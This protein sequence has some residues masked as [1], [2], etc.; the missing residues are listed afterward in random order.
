MT[1]RPILPGRMGSCQ[2]A[3]LAITEGEMVAVQRIFGTQKNII[4]SKYYVEEIYASHE[5]DVIVMRSDDRGN[6]GAGEA[7]GDIVED[8]RPAFV[9]LTGTAGGYQGREEAELGDVV[10]ADF[11]SYSEFRK[12][13]DGRDRPR[14]IAYDHPSLYLRGRFADQI[15]NSGSWKR[16]VDVDRPGPGDLKAIIGNLVAGEKILGDA[17]NPYQVELL[18]EFDK[19]VAFDMESFG[20]GR[21]VFKKRNSVHY[22]P[23]YL[24]IRGISD[25]VDQAEGSEDTRNLWRGY[26]ATVAA[27][28]AKAVTVNLIEVLG[29]NKLESPEMVETHHQRRI[30]WF[31]KLI[32][33]FG[34][35]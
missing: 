35:E 22:N 1:S 21:E 8:F 9:I 4:G 5:Y 23:Q 18:E 19:A 17:T 12:W 32:R 33:L 20:V 27:A 6:T 28:F 2:T 10:I 29:S 7:V 14:Y 16:Y 30:S 24:V 26:A 25:F 15:K 13:A 11:V 3:I 34:V 31:R